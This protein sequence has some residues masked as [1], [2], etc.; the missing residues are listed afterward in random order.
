MA[1]R[2]RGAARP[3]QTRPTRRPQQRPSG[4]AAATE[5]L[6]STTLRGPLDGTPVADAELDL[7][8]EAARGRRDRGRPEPVPA[9]RLRGNQTSTLL[10][11]RAAE[12]YGYVVKDVRRITVVGGGLLAVL[13]VLYV[14]IE[15]VHVVSL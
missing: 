10:A 11:A 7:P 6:R 1:K 3:G 15:V 5:A 12:E 13:V 8:V 9:A 4:S 2:S 14:L